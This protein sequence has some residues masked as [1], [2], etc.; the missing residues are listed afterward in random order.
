MLTS[1]ADAFANLLRIPRGTNLSSYTK[2]YISFFISGVF[3]AFSQMQMPCPVNI[4]AKERTLGFF[5]FFVWQAAFITFE[6]FVQW[7]SRKMN[8]GRLSRE[9]STLRI[10]IGYFWVTGAL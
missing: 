5:L 10:W 6:D 4:T 1:Y 3:H 8:F 9:N 7:L 2:L